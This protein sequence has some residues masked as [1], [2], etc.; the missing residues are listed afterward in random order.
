[1]KRIIAIVLAVLLLSGCQL[2]REEKKAD[3]L[4]DRLV[5]AFVTFAHL[6]LDY[7]IEG[8]LS[9]NP[10]TLGEGEITLDPAEGLAYAGRLPAILEEDGL[11]VPGYEGLSIVRVWKEDYTTTIT[12]EGVAELNSHVMAGDDGDSVAVEGTIYF[13]AG[14]EVMLC[15]NPV[16]MTE[17]G[18]YYVVQGQS[19]QSTVEKGGAMSQS[20]SDKKTW[21]ED[22]VETVCSA[23]FKTT[24]KGV[25]L[26]EKVV[27]VWMGAENVELSRMEYAPGELPESMT[28]A[29]DYLIVEEIAGETITR[30]LCQSG[31]ETFTVYYQGEQP[32]CV[33]DVVTIHWPE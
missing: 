10:G 26:A 28:A 16:Y 22:G 31:D 27:L 14:S 4:Q 7:D 12:S 19:F 6:E 23:E 5:G 15:L 21:T 2:A 9:D 8:W 13:P 1:M 25:S 32:W 3:R 24:V 11:V 30:Q 33:P 29:G 17:A 20:V 18:E